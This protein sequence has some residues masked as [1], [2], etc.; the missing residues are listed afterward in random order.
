MRAAKALTSLRICA[1]WSEPP[2]VARRCESS[3]G[4]CTV[5][6]SYFSM[7]KTMGQPQIKK[8][9]REEVTPPETLPNHM[10]NKCH[11][12]LAKPNV[13]EARIFFY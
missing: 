13:I 12:I 7:K 11:R 9:F 10:F 1:D 3:K 5:P 6:F 4:S 2:D 8:S